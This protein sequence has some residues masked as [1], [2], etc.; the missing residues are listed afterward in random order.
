MHRHLGKLITVA[1]F[2]GVFAAARPALATCSETGGTVTCTNYITSQTHGYECW[3]IPGQSGLTINTFGAGDISTTSNQYVVC[4]VSLPWN[5]YQYAYMELF[6][7]NNNP[8]IANVTCNLWDTGAWGTPDGVAL[9]V[10][11]GQATQC[12]EGTYGDQ[13]YQ[14]GTTYPL[15]S[16][17]GN[18]LLQC[19][20]PRETSGGNVSYLSM[21]SLEF[22]Y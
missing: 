3:S 8:S 4:P 2:L 10:A 1:M 11:L 18:F 13:C 5:D 7:Y 17:E 22:G 19:M 20:I 9:A 21:I 12:T 15:P 16:G 6:G 14:A